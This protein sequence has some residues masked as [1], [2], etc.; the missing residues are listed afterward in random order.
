MSRTAEIDDLAA[1]EVGRK[2]DLPC[3]LCGGRDYSWGDLYA[4]GLNFIP[5]SAPRLTR[6]LRIGNKLRGRRCESCGNVQMFA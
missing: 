2:P 5:D 4:A 3:H 1:G 6:I